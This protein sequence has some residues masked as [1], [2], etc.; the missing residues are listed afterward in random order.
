MT[1]RQKAISGLKWSFADNVVNLGLQFVVGVI[2]ARLLSPKEFG[3]IGM[4]TVFIA[5]AIAF[6]DSGFSQ[7]LI[8]KEKCTE[9]DY[10]TVFYFNISVGIV[11]YWLLFFISTPISRFYNEPKL[12][13]VVRVLALIIIIESLTVIQRTILTKNINFKLQ[14]KISIIASFLSG[15]VGI[16]LALLGYGVWSLVWRA[17]LQNVF[18][19]VLLWRWNRW[20]PARVF[21]YQSFREMLGFGSKL[22]AS[23]LLNTTFQNIYYLV[24]GKFFSATELGYYTKA[25]QFKALPSQNLDS[26]IQRVSYPVLAEI[27]NN[28]E[29][30]KK[31]YRR[32]IK[33]TTFIS[34]VSMIGM[35]AMARPLIITLIGAKWSSSIPILQLLCFSAILYPL[36]SLNL[37]MLKV[38]G[39]SDLFLKLEILKK[40]LVVPTVVLG[41]AFGIRMMLYCMVANSLIAYY[42]N[43]YWSGRLIEYPMTEQIADILPSFVVALI[44]SAVAWCLGVLFQ[45]QSQFLVLGAE[46]AAVFITVVGISSLVK[47]DVFYELKDIVKGVFIRRNAAYASK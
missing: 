22:L 19:S 39:K 6:I 47:L 16:L 21:D 29:R 42:L 4:V 32:L 1:L 3:L 15:G 5:I 10:S 25:D 12:V 13:D 41:V 28:D 40:L 36:Q 45:N 17:V 8:R 27:Q 30:L 35:A 18:I 2:L 34:F 14:T 7:A 43:S 38:K 11:V 46:M 9:K 31:A 26:V 24:I 33:N 20:R 44:G 37:N 23:G